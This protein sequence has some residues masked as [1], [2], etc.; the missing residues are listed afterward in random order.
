MNFARARAG[1]IQTFEAILNLVEDAEYGQ[2]PERFGEPTN[3]ETLS[4]SKAT[5]GGFANPHVRPFPE[6]ALQLGFLQPK[7]K[8]LAKNSLSTDES[9]RG[10][11]SVDVQAAVSTPGS[12]NELSDGLSKPNLL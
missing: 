11:S 3:V 7:K 6:E 2:F 1:D 5:I 12:A 9:R 4:G 10:V 8:D